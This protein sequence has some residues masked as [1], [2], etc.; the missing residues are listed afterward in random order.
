MPYIDSR[1]YKPGIAGAMPEKI[2]EALLLASHQEDPDTNRIRY[3][4]LTE[5]SK[6]Q[7]VRQA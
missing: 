4:A 1:R 3:L 2:G 7:N 5:M 6:G